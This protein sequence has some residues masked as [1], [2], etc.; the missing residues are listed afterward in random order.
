MTGSYQAK[1]SLMLCT[2]TWE[3]T[4]MVLFLTPSTTLHLRIA[5][6]PLGDSGSRM[7]ISTITTIAVLITLCVQ[8]V[9]SSHL[10][11]QLFKWCGECVP[12]PWWRGCHGL[13]L[14]PAGVQSFAGKQRYPLV[15]RLSSFSLQSC[16]FPGNWLRVSIYSSVLDYPFLCHEISQNL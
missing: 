15:I 16:L 6:I 14:W 13:V 2:K 11:I 10:A 9:L 1:K 5:F 12:N 3:I 8:C 4:L 7:E